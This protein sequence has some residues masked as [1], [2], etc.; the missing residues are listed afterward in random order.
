[1]CTIVRSVGK[2]SMAHTF[3]SLCGF[4][5]RAQTHRWRRSSRMTL[6]TR[7]EALDG[8]RVLL[9]TQGS[10]TA[11]PPKEATHTRNLKLEVFWLELSSFTLN[12]MTIKVSS[13][14]LH[15][16]FAFKT[17]SIWVRSNPS[18]MKYSKLI[19]AQIILIQYQQSPNSKLASSTNRISTTPSATNVGKEAE[20]PTSNHSGLDPN[21]IH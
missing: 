18:G 20:P 2:R 5:Q 19:K 6:V 14:Q 10:R 9:L 3:K 17:E 8:P 4:N 11:C 7:T 12:C 15:H 1:M 16:L 21:V 13:F